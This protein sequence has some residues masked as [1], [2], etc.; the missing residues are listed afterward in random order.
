MTGRLVDVP[1]VSH[2]SLLVM[3]NQLYVGA[4]QVTVLNFGAETVLARV[5]SDHIPAGRVLDLGTSQIIGEI[6][7]L[8]GFAVELGPWGGLA[9]IVVETE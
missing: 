6:D 4:A 7:A 9:A 2:R 8:G 3:V 5:Q 1:H